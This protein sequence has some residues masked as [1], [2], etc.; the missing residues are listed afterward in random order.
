MAWIYLQESEESPLLLENTSNQSSIAKK[1]YTVKECCFQE[2]P[3]NHYSIVQSGMTLQHYQDAA[4]MEVSTLYMEGFHARILALQE[5]EKAWKAAEVGYFSRSYAWP[6]KSSPHS[7]SLKMCQQLQQEGDFKLL[8]KLPKWGMIAD[9]VLY[10]L[11]PLEPCIDEKDGSYW[12]T[13]STMEHLPVRKGKALENALYRGKI[14]KSKRK[15]SGRLNEQVAYRQMWPTPLA[16]VCVSQANKPIRSPSPSRRNG[17]HGEDIQ[18]SVGRLNPET[19]G[20]KLC[21]KWVSVLMGYPSTWTD[22]E[23]WA[24]QYVHSKLKKRSKC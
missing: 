19:I 24:I 5:K 13:P 17:T 12:L 21:P 22:C 7:Y 1:T 23:P 20:K 16:T 10:P 14:H 2:W 6:K 15:V 9:G 4:S 11:L 18:D 8:E 3:M